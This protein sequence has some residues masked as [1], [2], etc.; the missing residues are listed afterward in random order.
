M[1]PPTLNLVE[2]AKVSV[3]MHKAG[4]CGDEQTTEQERLQHV[5]Q[6]TRGLMF[7]LNLPAESNWRYAG[8]D[9][10][11]GDAGTPIFWYRPER[12]ETYRVIYG[13]LSVMDVSPKNLPK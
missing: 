4:T 5:M 6:M 9:V 12:A 3:E 13:D 2:M 11:F 1:F 10:K 7:L 8:E